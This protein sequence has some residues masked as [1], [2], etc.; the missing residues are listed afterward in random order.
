MKIRRKS[1]AAEQVVKRARYWYRF[2]EYFRD[3]RQFFLKSVN[4]AQTVHNTHY[5]GIVSTFGE[6]VKWNRFGAE[7]SYHVPTAK[8]KKG[9]DTPPLEARTV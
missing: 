6:L 3:I 9:W 8:Q 5:F 2:S 7:N 1:L 4:D